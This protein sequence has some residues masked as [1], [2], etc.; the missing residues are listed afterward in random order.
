MATIDSVS[1][2]QQDISGKWRKKVTK[3]ADALGYEWRGLYYFWEQFA[4]CREMYSSVKLDRKHHEAAA[5][6]DVEFAFDQRGRQPD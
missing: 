3:L 4:L 6:R 5:Y 2:R 1:G